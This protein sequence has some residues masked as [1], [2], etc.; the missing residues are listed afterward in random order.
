MS[1]EPTSKDS[2][3]APLLLKVLSSAAAVSWAALA[4]VFLLQGDVPKI[5]GWL[6][7]LCAPLFLY[8]NIA[9]AVVYIAFRA[10]DSVRRKS[11]PDYSAWTW[12]PTLAVF[13]MLVALG[14]KSLPLFKKDFDETKDLQAL[15]AG[16]SAATVQRRYFVEH[17]KYANDLR[18]LLEMEPQITPAEDIT[19][20]FYRGDESGYYFSTHAKGSK[21]VYPFSNKGMHPFGDVKVKFSA[22]PSKSG[23][24]RRN[25]ADQEHVDHE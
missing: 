24:P 22:D 25:K 1:L 15:Q 3:K 4:A 9:V 12:L 14:I 10:V 17:K 5:I 6:G 7:K 23:L 20:K 19:F 8:G 21:V 18:S 11:W 16:Q 13:V 2:I